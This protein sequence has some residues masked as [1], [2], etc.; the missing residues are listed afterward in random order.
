MAQ[1]DIDKFHNELALSIGHEVLGNHLIDVKVN[2]RN[3][4][5]IWVEIIVMDNNHTFGFNA[6]KNIEIVMDELS[7]NKKMLRKIDELNLGETFCSIIQGIHE[8]YVQSI[9][10]TP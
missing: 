1:I 3:P 8:S 5:D 4:N 10:K 6:D 2:Y 7:N 9:V